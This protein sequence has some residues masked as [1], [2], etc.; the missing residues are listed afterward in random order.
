MVLTDFQK[1]YQLES[2]ILLNTLDSDKVVGL[3]NEKKLYLSKVLR[4]IFNDRIAIVPSTSRNMPSSRD[5]A[6]AP[7]W[8]HLAKNKD[9]LK[10]QDESVWVRSVSTIL[11]K[12]AKDYEYMTYGTFRISKE[13]VPT[14]RCKSNLNSVNAFVIDIDTSD[15]TYQEIVYFCATN[16]M[17]LPSFINKTPKGYH[18]WF[19]LSSSG[20][21]V[22]PHLDHFGNVT[23]VGKFYNDINK[24][25]IDVFSKHFNSQIQRVDKVFGGERYIRIPK[26]IIYWSGEKYTLKDFG[27]FKKEYDYLNRSRKKENGSLI[28]VKALTHD[29]AFK[30]LLNQKPIVG[31]RRR[32]V[33]TAA[34]VFYHANVSI[35]E[36]FQMLHKWYEHICVDKTDFSLREVDRTIKDAYKGKY[37]VSPSWIKSLTGMF[38]RVYFSNKKSIEER[39]YSTLDEQQRLFVDLLLHKQGKWVTTLRRALEALEMKSKKQLDRVICTLIKN[40][41]ITKKVIG[42]GRYA[43]T[44]FILNHNLINESNEWTRSTSG[45]VVIFPFNFNAP[46][47][48]R[49]IFTGWAG[50][51]RIPLI[52][53][54]DEIDT[55]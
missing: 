53:V 51:E 16:G 37:N 49:N 3:H 28:N 44:I 32:T 50:G 8:V 23:K 10:Y 17:P 41:I 22:G 42:K 12:V 5:S 39:I 46:L 36:C 30:K 15:I 34:L 33:F 14:D 2:D 55:S 1:N 13:R 11:R 24:S 21:A 47:S 31:Q 20:E 6:V 19:V 52:P 43:K 54:P 40:K 9:D 35:D 27:M 48:Y 45:K 4:F 7:G 18:V 29:P 38:P 26:H 25:L